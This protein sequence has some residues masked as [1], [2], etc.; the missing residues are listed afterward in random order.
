VLDRLNIEIDRVCWLQHITA[1]ARLQVVEDTGLPHTVGTAHKEHTSSLNKQMR[2]TSHKDNSPSSYSPWQRQEL[3]ATV[4]Q[5]QPPRR[6]T[7][8]SSPLSAEKESGCAQLWM[9]LPLKLEA[10][11]GRNRNA[12]QDKREGIRGGG[13]GDALRCALDL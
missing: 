13:G 1:T 9:L 6:E 10:A 4:K 8:M 12:K 7:T 11:R 3:K 2:H 5:Q